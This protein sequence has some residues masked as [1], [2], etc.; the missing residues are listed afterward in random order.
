MGTGASVWT[1]QDRLVDCRPQTDHNISCES[2]FTDLP[3]PS[4]LP[5]FTDQQLEQYYNDIE[6]EWRH[7]TFSPSH[8]SDDI[9]FDFY[10]SLIS[11]EPEFPNPG[12][13]Q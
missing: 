9:S 4:E 8:S 5:D 13:Y 10:D 6:Q 3:D 12:E 2:D 11:I 1:L 7:T